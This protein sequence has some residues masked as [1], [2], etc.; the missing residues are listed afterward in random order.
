M[1]FESLKKN[2]YQ[3]LLQLNLTSSS[4]EPLQPVHRSEMYSPY[5]NIAQ[6]L[7]HP[8]PQHASSFLSQSQY[9]NSVPQ[10]APGQQQQQYFPQVDGQGFVPGAQGVPAQGAQ[11]AAPGQAG[12]APYSAFLNDPATSMA[13]Q[14]A[15][16]SFGSSNQYIQQNFGSFIPGTLDL[17]YYFKVSNSYVMKKIGLILFPYRN[18]NWSRLTASDPAIS[19]GS[20]GIASPVGVATPGNISF[21]PPAYDVNAPDLYI[22]LMA[23]I[24][25]I[26]LW[27]LFQGIN[28]EFHPQLFG[29][30]ASQTLACS[31]LD[32]FIFKIGLYLLN[33]STQ[34][35]MWDLIAFSGY[36]YVSIIVLLCWKHLIGG[37]WFIYYAVVLT[38][39]ANLSLFLMRSLKFLV[40]PS[41]D[42]VTSTA[43]NSISSRQ[44]KLRIQFLFI[45]AVVVQF[46][47]ILFMSR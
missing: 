3:K 41:S 47:I 33:C 37:G 38:V 28:G 36:K 23:F 39:T 11:G 32:I 15:K 30:L 34:S 22:P 40:L 10:P 5:G 2:N 26:L 42:S 43:S 31:V 19:L 8:Q 12:G 14:F 13:A 45:Y 27:S 4:I 18:K 21:A 9:G 24:T 44:R 6:N 1:I 20:T 46:F 17:N 35:S 25:Y 29:Y 16:S 7:Q